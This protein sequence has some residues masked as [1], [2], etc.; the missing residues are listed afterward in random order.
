MK[1]T[2]STPLATMPHHRSVNCAYFSPDG[3]HLVTVGQDNFLH[4]Y[5]TRTTK[6]SDPENVAPTL[7]IPH[8]NQTGRW[9][10]KLHASWDPKHPTRYVIGCMQQPRRLQIFDA[11]RKNPVQELYSDLF[12]SVHSINVFH[13]KLNLI[14]GGNSSGRLCLWRPVRKYGRK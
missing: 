14:A 7:A 2:K 11:T 12:N 5:D 4:I 13:P 8:N 9:L 6:Y 1:K 10:T 3:A